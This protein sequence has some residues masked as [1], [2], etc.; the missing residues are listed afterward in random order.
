[1]VLV[2]VGDDDAV[3]PVGAFREPGDIGQD[4]VD[5]GR[6]VHVGK[7]HAEIHHRAAARCPSGP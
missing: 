2:P 7:G 6:G 4:Q 3:D 5:P 1:M